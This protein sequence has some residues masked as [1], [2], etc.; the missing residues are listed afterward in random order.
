MVKL[1]MLMQ[2]PLLTC[3][4][5]VLVTCLLDGQVPGAGQGQTVLHA[6]LATLASPHLGGHRC[7][8]TLQA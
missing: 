8:L 4:P 5:Q 1:H 6:A 2:F 3:L 7:P